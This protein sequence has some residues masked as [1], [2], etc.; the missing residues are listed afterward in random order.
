MLQKFIQDIRNA[1]HLCKTIV[2]LERETMRVDSDARMSTKPHPISL[3]S[4]YTH[5]LIKTDFCESQVEYATVPSYRVGTVLNSL[6]DL[7]AYTQQNLAGELL[8]PFSMPPILPEDENK[9][10]LAVYGDSEDARRKTLYRKG[11]GCRYGRRMQ[12]ISGVHINISFS[13][14]LMDWVSRKRFAKPLSKHTRS[15]LYLGTIRNFNRYAFLLLYFFGASPVLDRSFSKKIGELKEWGSSDYYGSFAT[16]IRL[17]ELGYTSQVQNTLS[18]SFN[19]LR[20]YIRDLNF[21]VSTPFAP[22][23]KYQTLTQQALIGN[24]QS[25]Y[26]TAEQLNDHYLQIENEYYALIRPKQIAKMGERPLEALKHR[27]IRYLEVRCVDSDPWEKTG[28]SEDAVLFTQ[29]FLLYCLLKDSPP[30][31]SVE[32][33]HWEQNQST[34]VWNGRNKD[35][36]YWVGGKNLSLS[37]V[38]NEIFPDIQ[39]IAEIWDSKESCSDKKITL[40]REAVENQFR[41]IQ[42]PSLTPSARI[43][44]ELR[45]KNLSLMEYGLSLSRLHEKEWRN[46]TLNPQWLEKMEILRKESLTPRSD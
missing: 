45:E 22:Y 16:T 11:L 9:I 30:M 46:R 28:V 44:T 15:E 14:S 5:P 38:A 40:Y 7:H 10:P 26:D 41:K 2:G 32:K 42:D 39:K 31:D 6:E 12:T 18:I 17:S 29:V 1:K 20:E 24:E 8:W 37:D 4:A 23:K 13:K 34:V 25:A 33:A 21:A 27:G 3:G 36:L 19:S 35:S 43:L